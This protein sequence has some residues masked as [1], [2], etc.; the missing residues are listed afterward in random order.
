[1]VA[2]ACAL[3]ALLVPELSTISES[4]N[5]RLPQMIEHG[6]SI[7]ARIK[8][9]RS[10]AALEA[11]IMQQL[12]HPNIV[13]CY[14]YYSGRIPASKLTVLQRSRDRAPSVDVHA[15]R[16]VTL[17]FQEYCGAGS[18]R[19]ALDNELLGKPDSGSE[20][21]QTLAYFRTVAQVAHQVAAGLGYAHGCGVLHCDVKS[22]NVLLQRL[23][24]DQRF[25]GAVP[26][27]LHLHFD[28]ATQFISLPARC[29][30]CYATR[31]Q[32][33]CAHIYISRHSWLQML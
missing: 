21:T 11:A 31:T 8:D 17:H 14:G 26:N 19:A 24:H 30:C 32:C 3:A 25:E 12:V 23:P 4:D 6:G 13:T 15:T 29:G 28:A 33:R 16:D 27:C 18:L 7:L 1:M 2:H 10:R 5:W 22:E 9:G 20:D